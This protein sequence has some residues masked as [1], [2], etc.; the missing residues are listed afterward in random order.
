MTHVHEGRESERAAR[1]GMRECEEAVAHMGLRGFPC[2]RP[3]AR[4]TFYDR[5]EPEQ[6]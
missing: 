6:E 1:D 5:P 4:V 2:P 3:T